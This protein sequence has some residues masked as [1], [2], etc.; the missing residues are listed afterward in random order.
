MQ[1]TKTAF[2]RLTEL[3]RA[4]REGRHPNALTFSSEYEVSQK[5]V[6]RD[7]DFLRGLGAPLGYDRDRK[8][9]YYTD[10]N[11]FLPALNLNQS[12]LQALLLA[13]MA[14]TTLKNTPVA[15]EY[16]RIL[17]KLMDSLPSRPNC[18]PEL[19]FAR[20][21]FTGTPA[22]RVDEKIWQT[23]ATALLTLHSVRISY[24]SANTGQ[25]SER[26]IDPYHMTN[27]QGEWYVLAW[28]HERKRIQQFSVAQIRQVLLLA[29]IFGFP[30][31]FNP[32]QLLG[33]VFR[34]QVLGDDV[35]E[36]RLRFDKSVA[37]R[38]TEREWQPR[39]KVKRLRNGDLELSFP[40]VGLFE[41][42]SWIL[43]WGNRVR[44]IGP[45]KLKEMVSA[46]IRLM[47]VQL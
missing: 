20:F 1:R 32:Q 2:T 8:G 3:D 39:Q 14:G 22:R 12:E 46:E 15:R 6:Q 28:C 7:I 26:T 10:A 18:P 27:L 40:A 23:L 47:K 21:S 44:V 30:E 35:Y 16:D 25:D 42:S 41:V 31:R 38:V 4:I 45:R 5:T 29:E 36:V 11:W 33:S 13:K 19:I 9:Y 34:R 17:G 24:H 37:E 43:S